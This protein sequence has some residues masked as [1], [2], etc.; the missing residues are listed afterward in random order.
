MR[1]ARTTALV[2]VTLVSL[3]LGL[4]TADTSLG[5]WAVC[6]HLHLAACSVLTGKSIRLLLT[7]CLCLIRCRLFMHLLH[8]KSLKACRLGQRIPRDKVSV[9]LVKSAGWHFQSSTTTLSQTPQ[10]LHTAPT[11]QDSN[12]PRVMTH[13]GKDTP[14]PCCSNEQ[15]RKKKNTSSSAE[16]VHPVYKSPQPWVFNQQISYEVGT[17]CCGQLPPGKEVSTE[18]P[19]NPRKLLKASCCLILIQVQCSP[20]SPQTHSVKPALC[21]ETQAEQNNQPGLCCKN[22]LYPPTPAES[23][24]WEWWGGRWGSALCICAFVSKGTH[25]YEPASL[26]SC[27]NPFKETIRTHPAA[28][29]LVK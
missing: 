28:A 15:C 26:V 1:R 16:D 2:C 11:T 23:T 12:T 27:K 8:E 19:R 10:R 14:N 21:A 18:L 4:L 5:S 20:K 13:S 29:I 3:W 6:S 25:Q 22:L 7:G 9:L 24:G 17:S